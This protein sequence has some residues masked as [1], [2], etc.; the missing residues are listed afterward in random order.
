MNPYDQQGENGQHMDY[1]P[2]MDAAMDAFYSTH[3]SYSRQPVCTTLCL[4]L[5]MLLTR[6]KPNYHLY[7]QPRP[8]SLQLR[9]FISDTER[10]ELQKRSEA[11]YAGP[12]PGLNLPEEIQGYHSL[13]PLEALTDNRRKFGNWLCAT[14][15]AVNST[16]G[17]TYVLRRVE[18]KFYDYGSL[19]S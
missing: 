5:T 12:T 9:Y 17:A 19:T 7:T 16:D 14:Y 3:S 15:K 1:D 2:A 18:S 13:V 6:S 4:C 10:E 11:V 8:E